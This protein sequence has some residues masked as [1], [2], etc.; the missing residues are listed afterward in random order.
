MGCAKLKINYTT[1]LYNFKATYSGNDYYLN[2]EIENTLNITSNVFKYS[3]IIPH[4]INV[5]G[6]WRIGYVNLLVGILFFSSSHFFC[7]RFD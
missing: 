6:V 2:C 5:S 1:G 7:C 4:Y 3:V